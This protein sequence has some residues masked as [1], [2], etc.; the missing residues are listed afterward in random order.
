MEITLKLYEIPTSAA[1]VCSFP[2]S[3]AATKTIMKA[4][5]KG[6]HAQ[7]IELLNAPAI[8]AV[9]KKFN[10]TYSITP[11]L[12]LE[13]HD[14]DDAEV[15]AHAEAFQ[16][17]AEEFGGIDYAVAFAQEDRDKL[18]QARHGAYW[19]AS[20]LC[21]NCKLFVTDV[22]VPIAK[23]AE[24]VVA[25]EDDFRASKFGAPPIVGHAGD[26]NYHVMLPLDVNNLS[27]VK[28][29]HELAARMVNRAIE[30]DG[31]C[32][33]EHGVGIGKVEFLTKE[34]GNVAIAMM[35]AIKKTLDPNNIMNPGKVLPPSE[36]SE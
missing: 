5:L 28:L 21:A 10:T 17:V 31:T 19:A 3:D 15:K 24:S 18:W 22:C 7:R 12:F 27:D 1:A 35:R 34:R 8:D 33:G 25:T 30:V 36:N 4:K 2:S 6:L 20:S 11:K 26:G 16:R 9:N 14:A 32:T 13:F 23:L 29:A